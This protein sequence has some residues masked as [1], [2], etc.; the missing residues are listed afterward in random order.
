MISIRTWILSQKVWFLII[1][2]CMQP[3]GRVSAKHKQWRGATSSAGAVLSTVGT[4]SPSIKITTIILHRYS[5][6]H[7][8]IMSS[9][10]KTTIVVHTYN[11][12]TW[13]TETKTEL[14]K[15]L[16]VGSGYRDTSLKQSNWTSKSQI[17]TF[18]PLSLFFKTYFVQM[19]KLCQSPRSHPQR[20][21]QMIC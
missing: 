18:S 15:E 17:K 14:L 21:F 19:L 20:G 12:S 13:E 10:H 7:F 2:R 6:I 5:Q 8:Y 3:S 4:S 16:R 11:P 1:T 9:W